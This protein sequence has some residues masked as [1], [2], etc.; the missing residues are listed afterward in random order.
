MKKESLKSGIK[1]VLWTSIVL[2]IGIY[3]PLHAAKMSTRITSVHGDDALKQAITASIQEAGDRI[4]QIGDPKKKVFVGTDWDSTVVADQADLKYGSSNVQPLYLQSWQYLLRMEQNRS[5][6]K[7]HVFTAMPA[8]KFDLGNFLIKDEIRSGQPID[9]IRGQ[10]AYNIGLKF[11]DK[12]WK[13]Q[14]HILA[15]DKNQANVG[16]LNFSQSS[17]QIEIGKNQKGKLITKPVQHPGT[18]G[19]VSFASTKHHLY[20][21]DNT[22]AHQVI[23]AIIVQGRVIYWNP[24]HWQQDHDQKWRSLE[25]FLNIRYDNLPMFWPFVIFTDDSLPTLQAMKQHF[26]SIKFNDY[27]LIHVQ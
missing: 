19:A 17:V 3:S 6:E 2:L 23:G 8:R 18:R 9:E 16:N 22:G 10:A 12:T 13:I 11:S 20:L 4:K 21:K 1:H 5:I 26:D 14:E 24:I 27:I 15:F 25:Y 7:I